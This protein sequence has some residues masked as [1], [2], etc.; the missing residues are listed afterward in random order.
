M[1]E[2]ARFLAPLWAERSQRPKPRDLVAQAIKTSNLRRVASLSRRSNLGRLSRP[3]APLTPLSTYWSTISDTPNLAARLQALAAPGSVVI[4]QATRRLVG[5]LFELVD[6]GPQRLKGFAEPLA[7]WQV[8]GEGRAE[9]RFEALHGERLTP[10]VGREHELGILLERWTWAKDG[11][12]HIVLLAGEPGI[13]KSRLTRSLMERLSEEPLTCLRYYG[14]P[15]H[16]NSALYPIIEQLERAA[17]FLAADPAEAKLDKLEAMLAEGADNPAAITPLI[18]L[19]LSIPTGEPCPAVSL[20]PE[21]QKA[22]TFDALL[23]QLVGLAR[24]RPVLMVL[25]DAHWIDPTTSELFGLMIDSI[26]RLPVLLVITFR[27]EFMPPWTGQA[28]LTSL[29]L[30][31]L[32]QRQGAQMI[33]RLTG[34]KPLPA[35]VLQQ[36]LRKTDGVPLFV[37]ELTKTL[38]E[39]GL[40]ADKGDQYELAGPLPPLAMPTTL[41]DSLMARLDRLAPAREVAQIGAVIGREFSH[42]LVAAIADRSEAD[43]GVALDQLVAS[44]LVFRRGTSPD[45]TYTFKHVLVQDAAYQS[46]L[47]SRRQQLHARIAQVLEERLPAASET[48][49]EV[50][51]RHLTDAGLAARAIPYWCR[52]GELAAARSTRSWPSGWRSVAR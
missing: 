30:S 18:A 21:A 36:I 16:T 45:A 50:L 51:A 11:E 29:A 37:E 35:E 3:L 4:S 43:L 41:H 42:E 32:G 47:K 8:E 6:L 49:P 17:R 31:R 7:V 26:Q 23:E 10:L 22:R 48:G 5:G 1:P 46:L 52:A 33:E 25:E 34:S 24:R 12:G 38:L 14:S 15:Y 19:L 40:L 28:H 13:G 2:A 9:G 20:T 44:E 27:P 39:S